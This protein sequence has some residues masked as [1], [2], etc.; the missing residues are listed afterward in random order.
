ML[1][2]NES[3]ARAPFASVSAEA[4]YG[5]RDIS[6]KERAVDWRRGVQL[7]TLRRTDGGR[8]E[9]ASGRREELAVR[10]TCGG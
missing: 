4:D 2:E 6:G 1:R 8:N 5:K 10:H 9:I 7:G 3:D